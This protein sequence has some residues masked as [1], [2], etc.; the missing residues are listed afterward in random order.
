LLKLR[1]ETSKEWLDMVFSDFDSFLIEHAACERKACSTNMAF[2][3][4]YPDRTHILDPMITTAREELEHFHQVYKFIEKRGLT[5]RPDKKDEYVLTLLHHMHS[6]KNQRFL[7]RLL[8]SGVVEARG[9][10]RLGLISKY[11]ED[12]ELKE[13]YLELVRCEARHHITFIKLAEKYFDP[14]IVDKRLNQFLDYEAEAITK[15]PL[16]VSLF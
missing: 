16:S 1:T 9:C 14:E 15:V 5:L 8:I 6:E 12:P 3:V 10:E 11:V 13:F 4:K 2:V 7:D